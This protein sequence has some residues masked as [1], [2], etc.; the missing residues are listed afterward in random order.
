MKIPSKFRQTCYTSDRTCSFKLASSTK[1]ALRSCRLFKIIAR[2]GQVAYQ[3]ALPP[4]LRIHNVF[5]ISI[6]KKYVHDATHVI[7]WNVIEVELEGDFSG[8]TRLYSRQEGNFSLES[9]HW[10][11]KGAMETPQSK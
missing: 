10:I 7:E 9:Y 3:L 6:L 4:N 11:G 2:V 5:H 1:L 8:G